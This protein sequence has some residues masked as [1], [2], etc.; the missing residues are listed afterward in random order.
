MAA[1]KFVM[2]INTDCDTIQ[3]INNISTPGFIMIR[4]LALFLACTNI[5]FAA[6]SNSILSV[7]GPLALKMEQAQL[8]FEQCSRRAPKPEGQLWFPTA[9]EVGALEMQLEK[10]MATLKFDNPNRPPANQQYRGQYVGFMRNNVKYIYASYIP[11]KVSHIFP[12]GTAHQVCDGG[13]Q[14]WGIVYNTTT[15]QFSEFEVNGP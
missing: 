12:D 15:A 2:V 9:A 3:L 7:E 11:A 10:H 4:P 1:Y 13:A 6:E 14:F 8:L 5:V